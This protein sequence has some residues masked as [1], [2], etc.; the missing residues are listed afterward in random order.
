M[1]HKIKL[2]EAIKFHGHL[3]PYLVIGILAGEHAIKKLKAKKYFGMQVKV[4]GAT[5]KPKSCLIDG[6]QLSTGATYGKGNI[7]KFNA[8]NIHIEIIENKKGRKISIDLTK[9]LLNSL[10]MVKTHKES[11]LLAKKIYKTKKI[12]ELFIESIASI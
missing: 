2:S 4:W 8:R 5:K 1:E 7:E 12:S 11:E 10:E 9:D 6:L 3:G